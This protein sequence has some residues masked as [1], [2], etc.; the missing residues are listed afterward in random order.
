MVPEPPG[1]DLR[2]GLIGYGLAGSVFHAPVIS[3]VPGLRL[4]AVV[5]A[6]AARG[7]AARAR[8][9]DVR[10]VP[11]VEE[12]WERAQALDAVVIASPNRTHVPLGLA[13]L[14]AGLHVVVDKPMAATA[15]DARR[16]VR[17]AEQAGRLLTVYHNR[18]WDAD[19]LTL[20]RLLGEGVL[21]DVARFESRFERWRP[22]PKP[23]WRQDPDPADAGGLLYDLAP[24]LVD[25]AL[26]LFGPAETVYAELDVRRTGSR[27]DDDAFVALRHRSGVRSHLWMSEVAGNPGPRMRVL[28]SSGSWVKYGMDRQESAL[29]AGERPDGPHWGA[30]PEAAWGSLAAGAEPR[31]VPSEPGDYRAFYAGLVAALRRGAPAPVDP[32]DAVA[33]LHVMDAARESAATGCVVRIR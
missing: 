9:A 21:G 5:T 33:V 24:H 22:E 31:P 15:A 17:A 13:A 16:L 11:A 8:Y 12:L 28:G 4:A 23:G 29:R 6:D 1:A 3:A 2:I 18:R 30:E 25:Q 7:E 14:A 10:V 19:F 26:S 20:R 27:V 32:M